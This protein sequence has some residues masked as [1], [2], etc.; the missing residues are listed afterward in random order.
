MTNSIESDGSLCVNVND[1]VSNVNEVVFLA[2]VRFEKRAIFRMSK[3]AI[4]MVK[5]YNPDFN[6]E[7]AGLVEPPE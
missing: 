4:E 7:Y 3:A 2:N 5:E 6:S 1:V